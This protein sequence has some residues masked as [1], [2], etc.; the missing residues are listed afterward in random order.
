MRA[1]AVEGVEPMQCPI[2]KEEC[3]LG[4]REECSGGPDLVSDFPISKATLMTG[5][6]AMLTAFIPLA[7]AGASAGA[8]PPARPRAVSIQ[9]RI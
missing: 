2:S 4:D 1:A 9:L 7:T 8:P 5:A 3:D 6:P